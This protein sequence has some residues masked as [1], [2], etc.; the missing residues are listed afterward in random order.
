[1][2]TVRGACGKETRVSSDELL[3]WAYSG[4]LP[5]VGKCV[6]DGPRLAGKVSVVLCMSLLAF[7][8]L[9]AVVRPRL[10]RVCRIALVAAGIAGLCGISLYISVK[11][12]KGAVEVYDAATKAR[13]MILSAGRVPKR[14]ISVA[15]Q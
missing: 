1:M 11:T 2:V 10:K 13:I 5:L 9:V 7:A 4:G 3:A 6:L 15:L 12:S 14:L 8:L